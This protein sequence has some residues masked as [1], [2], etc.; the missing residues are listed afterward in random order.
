MRDKNNG[1]YGNRKFH[2]QNKAV[3]PSLPESIDIS[4]CDICQQRHGKE[5]IK[6]DIKESLCD[7]CKEIRDMGEPLQEYAEWAET[8]KQSA[9]FKVSLDEELLLAS[10]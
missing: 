2:L 10:L 3:W 7:V 4:L 5:Y 6:E 9:W 8:G 1:T